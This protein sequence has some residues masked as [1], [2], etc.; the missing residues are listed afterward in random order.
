VTVIVVL[1]ITTRIT[2][3][4]PLATPA[5]V[6]PLPWASLQRNTRQAI[7]T[8]YTMGNSS[9]RNKK[10]IYKNVNDTTTTNDNKHNEYYSKYNYS[11]KI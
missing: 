9:G 3:T 8:F 6:A 7:S 10:K 1:I 2:S 4:R 11:E 5:S